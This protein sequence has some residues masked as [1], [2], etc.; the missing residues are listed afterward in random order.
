MPRESRLG[1]CLFLF[2]LTACTYSPQSTLDPKSGTAA[3]AYDL[4][5]P[6]FWAAVV[7]FV[8]VEALLVYSVLR[9]R[10]RAD[11]NAIPTQFHGN[12][13]LEFGWTIAPGIVVGVIFLLPARTVRL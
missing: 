3:A 8:I 10:A 1:L 4:L 12:T 5:V 2:S 7:V 11:P 6:I 9:F 13:P